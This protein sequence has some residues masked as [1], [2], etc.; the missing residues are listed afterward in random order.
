MKYKKSSS[1]ALMQRNLLVGAALGL[2]YGIFYRPTNTDP[3]YI[4]AIVLSVAAALITVVVRFWGKKPTFSEIAVS[5]FKMLLLYSL[6]LLTLAFR[7]VIDQVGGR[8][9]LAIFTTLVGILMGYFLTPKTVLE[10][11]KS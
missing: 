10:K 6:F 7:H 5:F 9:G 4:I 2:Y 8:V 1:V 11:P 3:D